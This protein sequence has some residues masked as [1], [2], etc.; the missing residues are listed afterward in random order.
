MSISFSSSQIQT[1]VI[2]FNNCLFQRVTAFRSSGAAVS[3]GA[4]FFNKSIRS[5]HTFHLHIKGVSG[6]LSGFGHRGFNALYSDSN[7][8][9]LSVFPSETREK[10]QINS[11]FLKSAILRTIRLTFS[12]LIL[13]QISPSPKTNEPNSQSSVFPR[14]FAGGT[15]ER[16]IRS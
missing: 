8:A 15:T 2:L 9:V 6:S 11:I 13:H 16:I 7:S 1:H 5:L 3:L 14:D 10:I 4:D 12:H